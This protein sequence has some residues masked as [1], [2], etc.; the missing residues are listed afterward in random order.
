MS[1]IPTTGRWPAFRELE[2]RTSFPDWLLT[3]AAEI[4]E[5]HGD[6]LKAIHVYF[7]GVS[8]YNDNTCVEPRAAIELSWCDDQDRPSE[9]DLDFVPAMR[10]MSRRAVELWEYV[11]MDLDSE[12]NV[13]GEYNF[14][15]SREGLEFCVDDYSE[16]RAAA[17]AKLVGDKWDY[18][19]CFEFFPEL[20][21][22]AR[23][24]LTTA[25]VIKEVDLKPYFDNEKVPGPAAAQWE[26]DCL[27]LTF[28]KGLFP[29][30]IGRG[31]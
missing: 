28:G 16:N 3:S 23:A 13:C 12:A 5:A 4:V 6:R 20:S 26:D 7:W 15:F 18:T 31:E 14:T 17:R 1:E 24:S 2:G 19:E 29:A 22:I 11:P 21:E 8:E 30:Y 10:R 27:I 25:N 9:D